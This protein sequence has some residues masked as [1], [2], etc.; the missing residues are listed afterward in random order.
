MRHTDDLEEALAALNSGSNIFL[1]GSAGSGKTTLIKR[2]MDETNQKVALCASTGIA[3]IQV[4]GET[5]HRFLK[6]GISCRPNEYRKIIGKWRNVRNS[7]KPWDRAKWKTITTVDTIVIDEVSMIRRDQFELLDHVLRGIRNTKLPFGGVQMV[8]VGDMCQLPPVVKQEELEFFPD[9]EEPYTFQSKSWQRGDFQSFNLTTNFR[10]SSGNFLDALEQIRWGRVTDEVDEMLQARLGVELETEIQPVCLYSTNKSV[11]SKNQKLLN[12]IKAP[13][14]VSKATFTGKEFDI[15]IMKKDCMA[16]EN[17]VYCEGAQVMMLNNDKH[18]RWVNGTMGLITKCFKDGSVQVRFANGKEE[19]VEQHSWERR[20]PEANKDG[21]IEFK[22]V[23]TMTQLPFKLAYASTIHK[24]VVGE[25]KVSTEEGLK[26][27]DRLQ[28]T[29][30]VLTGGTANL[31]QIKAHVSTGT[32]TVVRITTAMGYSIEVSPEHPL[33]IAGPNKIPTF[34]K[35]SEITPEDFACI[36]RN[37]VPGNATPKLPEKPLITSKMKRR[38]V[39]LPQK[40]TSH[41]AWLL[42]LIIGDGSY[43]DRRDGTIEI[44]GSQRDIEVLEEAERLLTEIFDIKSNWRKGEKTGLY[45]ISKQFREWL[46]RIGLDYVT[47]PNKKTP[48]LI[49][50]SSPEIRAAYLR[51]LADSD[52]S[53]SQQKVRFATSSEMLATEI[54]ELLRSLGILAKKQT[55]STASG[56][57]K[58]EPTFHITISGT[59]LD[60]YRELVGFN[61]KRKQATL[62]SACNRTRMH[63][64][65]VDFIP[66]GHHVWQEIQKMVPAAQYPRMKGIGLAAGENQKHIKHVVDS[67]KQGSRMTYRHLR[68]LLSRLDELGMKYPQYMADTLSQNYLF[69]A[70]VE[71]SITDKTTEMYDIEV[72]DRHSFVANGFV[73]HNSQGLTLDFAEMD[74]ADAFAAGQSYVALSRVRNLEGLRLRGWDRKSVFADNAVL[75]FYGKKGKTA[76]K[77]KSKVD[78]GLWNFD[79]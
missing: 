60:S 42:G 54:H 69:D 74:L 20:V 45:W 37:V 40:L 52:G 34:I 24:C 63:K 36:D 73:C 1:T 5:I 16:E 27:M 19:T 67:L 57:R 39:R 49:F 13:K 62:N 10:Q 68:V 2:F 41:L 26:A 17:L 71:A 11:Q 65:E 7:K 28:T 72:E 12:Q 35:A 38:P 50:S 48:P 70:V 9:L 66:F 76:P 58:G 47:A 55:L 43:R 79:N 32:Q 3:A 18:N 21:E 29:N 61:L 78:Y 31:S 15:N 75:E 44:S 33:L 4:G 23:S 77:K 30:Q 22:M 59:A 46:R 51:G 56:K 6:L 25:T 64:T 53:A 8:L 14:R